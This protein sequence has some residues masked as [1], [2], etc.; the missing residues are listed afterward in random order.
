MGL[1]GIVWAGIRIAGKLGLSGIV[2]PGMCSLRGSDT[3]DENLGG[4]RDV[5]EPESGAGDTDH[6]LNSYS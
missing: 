4:T 3:K 6:S 1:S 2:W 5:H